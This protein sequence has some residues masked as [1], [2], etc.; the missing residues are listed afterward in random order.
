VP[1]V[2]KHILAQQRISVNVA[3]SATLFCRSGRF[4][5]D[6]TKRSEL[7][8]CPGFSGFHALLV[9]GIFL[10]VDKFDFVC[11]GPQLYTQYPNNDFHV[12]LPLTQSTVTITHDLQEFVGPDDI[13]FQHCFSPAALDT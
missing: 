3:D 9:C 13:D 4:V 8:G 10:V 1:P 11:F 12:C 7:L 5:F 6:Q 2:K